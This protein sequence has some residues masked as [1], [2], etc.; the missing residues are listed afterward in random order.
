MLENVIVSGAAVAFLL[1]IL[2]DRLPGV[3]REVRL[4][5]VG[6][7][8]FLLAR[9]ARHPLA[10]QSVVRRST[11]LASEAGVSS[12][13]ILGR[14]SFVGDSSSSAS[15]LTLQGNKVVGPEEKFIGLRSIHAPF[16]LQPKD[17][18]KSLPW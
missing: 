15:F 4:Q 10:V 5:A 13:K 17:F 1:C 7:E 2:G 6:E 11:L 18:L 16:C 9:Q 14:L 8:I 12:K 3:H